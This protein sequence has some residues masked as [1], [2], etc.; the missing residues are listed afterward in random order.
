MIRR[1]RLFAWTVS[2]CL[3]A[4]AALATDI[5]TIE[6]SATWDGTDPVPRGAVLEVD[7][8]D[9]TRSGDGAV[10]SRMRF[11]PD[12]STPLPFLLHY[13]A[14]LVRR[15]ERYSLAARLVRGEDVLYRSRTPVPVLRTF[16]PERPQITMHKVVPVVASGTPVGFSWAVASIGGGR[17]V[18]YSRAY[19]AFR[20]DG[21]ANGSFGCNKFKALYTVDGPKIEFRRFRPT[22]RG[23]TTKIANQERAIRAAIRRTVTYER[24]GERLVFLDIAGLETLSFERQ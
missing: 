12:L 20:E 16:Q 2:V 10:L 13:D 3:I 17:L 18:R 8:I 15:G 22:N 1:T 11:K 21:T 6:G 19:I 23:C 14:D 24:D 4:S 7:L 9:L 5:E